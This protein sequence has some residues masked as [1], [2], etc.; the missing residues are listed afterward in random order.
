MLPATR[1]IHRR[2]L[3]PL[4]GLPLAITPFQRKI[5]DNGEKAASEEQGGSS[6]RDGSYNRGV[7]SISS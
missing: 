5:D 4:E 7:V 2:P 3:K 1:E 6:D